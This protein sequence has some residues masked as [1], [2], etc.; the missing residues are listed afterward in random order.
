MGV[1][2]LP[3]SIEP[4]RL[5]D[6]SEVEVI[7]RQSFS[8]PWSRRSYEYDLT[9]N[10]LARYIVVRERPEGGGGEGAE[11]ITP[12]VPSWI[13]RLRAALRSLAYSLGIV[14]SPAPA[15]D[16]EAES[17]PQ[18][19]ILGFAGLWLAVEEA[20]LVTI[21]V[22]PELRRRGLGELLLVSILDLACSMHVST[23]LLEVRGS[24]AAARQLY[25]KYGFTVS[26]IRKGYYSDNGEDGV[27]MAAEGINKAPF[28][29]RLQRLKRLLV[30]RL[31]ASAQAP[32]G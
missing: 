12:A 10:A 20:H 14:P 6:V 15:G 13:G 9:Q 25:E 27:E 29:A 23:M 11:A 8:S 17:G 24:N 30:S 22:R 3:Y 26:R 31:I 2:E 32:V 7:E 19:P 1:S 21:A 18:P 5:S 4:M 16:P 28:Q